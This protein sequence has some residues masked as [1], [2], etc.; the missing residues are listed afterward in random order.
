MHG[1]QGGRVLGGQRA[2]CSTG[3][4]AVDGMPTSVATGVRAH[5]C[6][7]QGTTCSADSAPPVRGARWTTD[8]HCGQQAHA[9]RRVCPCVWRGAWWT[10]GLS[11]RRRPGVHACGG[12]AVCHYG[13][14]AFGHYVCYRRAPT[15]VP[16]RSGGRVRACA[17]AAHGGGHGR[18]R[19]GEWLHISDARVDHCG[20]AQVLAE[21]S[22]VFRLYYER[23]PPP[24]VY[25]GAGVADSAETLRPAHVVGPGPG[26]GFG[27][28][29]GGGAGAGAKA[30][31]VRSVSL[32]VGALARR[33]VSASASASSLSLRSAVSVSVS[34]EPEAAEPGTPRAFDTAAEAA[35]SATAADSASLPMLPLMSTSTP[36]RGKAKKK[37]KKGKQAAQAT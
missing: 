5:A 19:G 23:V 13:Q 3:S 37:K 31:V 12:L 18:E 16:V 29:L 21:G 26:T 15:P 27:I 30:R 20:I 10:V 11:V 24:P 36:G 7:G 6:G 22:A 35:D 17:C 8:P 33:S 9:R 28:A 14:H 32:G 34:P 4:C 25:A 1:G 2:Q